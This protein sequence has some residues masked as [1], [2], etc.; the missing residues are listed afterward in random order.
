MEIMVSIRK[1]EM[2]DSN[3]GLG[4]G[5]ES[6]GR[7]DAREESWYRGDD[8]SVSVVLERTRRRENV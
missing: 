3:L 2:D 5:N 4:N 6:L 1:L 8:S 7:L